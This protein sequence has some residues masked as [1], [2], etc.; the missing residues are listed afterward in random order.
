MSIAYGKGV[1]FKEPYE[2]LNGK[3]F[4]NFIRKHFNLC[5]VRAG[6]KR[7]GKRILAMG[8]DPSQVS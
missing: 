3:F 7:D 5:F 6:P 1:I 4:V 2:K 8:N